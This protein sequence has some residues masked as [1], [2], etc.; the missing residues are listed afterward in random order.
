MK[1]SIIALTVTCA[2]IFTALPMA[3]FAEDALDEVFADTQKK[4]ETVY[5]LADASGSVNKIIVSDHFTGF[6]ADEAQA[7][8]ADIAGLADVENV[9]GDDYWQGIYENAQD[10]PITINVTCTLDDEPVEAAD[11]EGRSGH[12]VMRY[13]FENHRD[14]PF[15]VLTGMI[16]NSRTVDNVEAENARI[17]NV[18]ERN[19]IV[20]YALPGMKEDLSVE[21]EEDGQDIEEEGFGIDAI[22]ETIQEKENELEIP[23]HVEISA[24]VEDYE[25]AQMYILVS[26]SIFREISTESVENLFDDPDLDTILDELKDGMTTLSDGTSQISEGLS[27]LLS[28]SKELSN[29]VGQ[30]SDGLE[31]LD[32]SGA[33]L[34]E[35]AKQVF[36]ALLA[37]A[38]S[39]IEAGGLEIEPLTI[40]N[41]ETVLNDLLTYLDGAPELAQQTAH[42][43]VE[44]AV[45]AREDE[46]RAV[47]TDAVRQEVSAQVIAAVQEEVTT[48][49]TAAVQDEVWGQILI[50][51]GMDAD[52]YAQ[53][54]A[55]G[56]I[57]DEQK[58]AAQ[59]AL[60]EQMASDQVQAMIEANVEEQ[61]QGEEAQAGITTNT[62]A[63]M[64]SAMVQLMVE[65]NVKEQME[66]LVEENYAS[67]E[68]QEQIAAAAAQA[69]AGKEQIEGALEQLASFR[70]FYDGVAEYTGGVSAAAQGA[71][72]LKD[73]MPGM[74]LGITTLDLGSGVLS[75]ALSTLQ[76][77]GTEA[78]DGIFDTDL[79]KIKDR[80]I[81]VIDLEKEYTS[82][83]A[84]EEG[85]ESAVKFIYKLG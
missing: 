79:N 69:E 21:L 82:F 7:Y 41:Y 28:G 13:D 4:D 72:E 54:E 15:M 33:E 80:L 74:V 1:K 85:M 24:D 43:Q 39:Q 47:V 30:L 50:S 5:V 56:L 10:L 8:M 73:S 38:Q 49:V 18:G 44:A 27:E 37:T 32:A 3:V 20:G 59:A 52:S 61:M 68:V 58:A 2:L 40:D 75:E 78:I 60:E 12:L 55:A 53:A 57:S 42:E 81:E 77:K 76:E 35:G 67:D 23:D 65:T 14:I 70:A 16:L 29:G 46:V 63:Q 25:P 64:E 45:N 71:A 9:R 84:N 83:T 51:Q 62:Q 19:I 6:S 48:Q 66:S 26:N 11:L 31:T 17:L 34:N 22:R 36:E